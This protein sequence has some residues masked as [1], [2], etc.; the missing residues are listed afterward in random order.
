MVNNTGAD[1]LVKAELTGAPAPAWRLRLVSP[2]HTLSD[3]AQ[4]VTPAQW[5]EGILL[6]TDSMHLCEAE[7]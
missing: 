4:M 7:A 5:G 3:P 1:C 2:E 6:P